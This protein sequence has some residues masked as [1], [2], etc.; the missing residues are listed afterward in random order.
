M[1]I[2]RRKKLIQ[3]S[4]KYHFYP[5]ITKNYNFRPKTTKTMMNSP[6]KKKLLSLKKKNSKTQN[7]KN[8][9]RKKINTA[10]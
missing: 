9:I 1:K 4:K 10:I 2:D 6:L 7:G 5:K 8:K 3:S